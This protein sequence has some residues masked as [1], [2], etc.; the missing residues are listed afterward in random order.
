MYYLSLDNAKLHQKILKLLKVVFKNDK[1][2][3]RIFDAKEQI[4]V[5]QNCCGISFYSKIIDP[6]IADWILE[7]EEKE[8][9][10][11]AMVRF[12]GEHC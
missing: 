7:P 4:K 6:K 11:K 10:L 3:V 9:N 2:R 12:N 5:L 8:K 1:V